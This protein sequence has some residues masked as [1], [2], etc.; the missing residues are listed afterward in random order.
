VCAATLAELLAE[1]A[2]LDALRQASDNRYER[3]RALFFLYDIHRFHLPDKP[4][5]RSRGFVP[6]EGYNYLLKRRFEEGIEVVS[7]QFFGA[8]LAVAGL[9][10]EPQRARSETGPSCPQIIEKSP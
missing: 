5:I 9:L 1:C 7:S 6:F 2:S 3:V 4:G 10:T 8:L